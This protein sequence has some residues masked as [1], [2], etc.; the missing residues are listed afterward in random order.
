[1]IALASDFLIFR[2]DS[3][4]SIPY[5]AEMIVVELEGSVAELTDLEFATHAAH[6]VFYYFKQEL[7]R[8]TVT[9][10]EFTEALLTVLRGFARSSRVVA[11]I[12][13]LQSVAEADLLQLALES[14]GTCE[15]LFFA[16]LRSELRSRLGESPRLL[17]FRSLRECVKQ[18]VATRRWSPRCRQLESQIVDYLRGCLS[19]ENKG[20]DFAMLI[21]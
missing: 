10:C 15:L 11:S 6:A 17:R 3:G 9:V 7:N 4:E 21:E 19:A 13:N 8:R 1:M 18:L 14:G 2:T 20:T 16:R 5:S 12:T